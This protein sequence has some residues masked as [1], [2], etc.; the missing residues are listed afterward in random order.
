VLPEAMVQL[1]RSP[2]EPAPHRNLYYAPERSTSP[3]YP[4]C[5]PQSLPTYYELPALFGYD[6]IFW[7]KNLT[8]TAAFRVYNDPETALSAYGVRWLLIPSALAGPGTSKTPRTTLSVFDPKLA[9]VPLAECH[10][11]SLPGNAVLQVAEL[12]RPPA[13]LCFSLRAPERALPVS[14]DSEGI[15]VDLS[16]LDSTQSLVVNFLRWPDMVASV[17]GQSATIQQDEW[18][19]MVIRVPKGA[20]KLAVLYQSPWG[21]GAADGIVCVL[22]ALGGLVVLGKERLPVLSV[23]CASVDV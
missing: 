8:G 12:S 2:G 9:S 1:L 6:P 22:L 13:P 23:P 11:I 10:P 19:R 16:G 15:R 5:L 18:D 3:I 7:R 21:Q 4:Y 17:D 20:K 14:L